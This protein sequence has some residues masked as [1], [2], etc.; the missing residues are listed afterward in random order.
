MNNTKRAAHAS[1]RVH[2]A[3]SPR[4]A[5]RLTHAQASGRMG[6]RLIVVVND[7]LMDNHQMELAHAMRDAGASSRPCHWLR[8]E[9]C[10]P[11]RGVRYRLLCVRSVGLVPWAASR[12][13]A[14]GYASVAVPSGGPPRCPLPPVTS[15]GLGCC[16][17]QACRSLGTYPWQQDRQPCRM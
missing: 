13:H 1:A 11:P 2:V 7:S 4:M 6:K 14:A 12:M 10:P 3:R 15:V 9:G 8:V 17:L 16:R 5:P